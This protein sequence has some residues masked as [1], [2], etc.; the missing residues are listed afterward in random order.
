MGTGI[1]KNQQ[2]C[3]IDIDIIYTRINSKVRLLVGFFFFF[4]FVSDLQKVGQY[5]A[6]NDS[7]RWAD[8]GACVIP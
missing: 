2:I 4:F 3:H 6:N 7:Y 1:C 5:L 8:F